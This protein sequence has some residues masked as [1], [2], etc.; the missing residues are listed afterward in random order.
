MKLQGKTLKGVYLGLGSNIGDRVFYIENAISEISKLSGTKIINISSLYETE[1]WGEKNQDDYLNAAIEISP[2]LDAE[3]L[4]KKLKMIEQNSGR[5]QRKKWERREIDIDILF[6][7]NEIIETGEMKIPHHEI[8]NRKF[9]LIPMEEIA[10]D[11]IHPVLK[12][13]ISKLLSETGDNLKVKKYEKV[14]LKNI[15]R[16]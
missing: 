2:V 10:G 7:G 8:E 6:Y 14:N 5:S 15:S 9:V 16:V 4:L 3:M 11:Y 1:P 12:I 13:P